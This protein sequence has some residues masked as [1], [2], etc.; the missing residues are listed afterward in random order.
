MKARIVPGDHR[1]IASYYEETWLDYRMI[2]LN[3]VNRAIHLGYWDEKTKSHSDSLV[4]MNRVLA[5]NIRPAPGQRILDAGCG[6][7]GTAMWLAENYDIRVVGI[8]VTPDQVVRARRYAEERGLSHR[9]SFGLQDY[10]RTAF[11]DASFEVVYGLESICYAVN[12]R[13]FLA[14]A[15]RLLKP[16]GRLVVQDGFR[17]ERPYS[18]EEQR[19]QESWLSGW[20]V[21]NLATREEFARWA[22]EVGFADVEDRDCTDAVR[23]SCRRLYRVTMAC[24]PAAVA[25]HRMG[26]RSDI[27]QGN[28]RAARDQYRALLRGLWGYGIVT[29]NKP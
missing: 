28:V 7:G 29:A 24:Y 13:D 3:R 2:W 1:T 5:G 14:D 4:N 9:V 11:P 6:V 23:P 10:C 22:S 21:P 8:T 27:Q 26:A 12:K 20:V 18:D 16:G 17:V 25:L 19:L 15:Y